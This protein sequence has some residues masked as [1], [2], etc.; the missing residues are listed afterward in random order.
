MITAVIRDVRLAGEKPK[1]DEV[2]EVDQNTPLTW[3]V[4][5][6][7]SLSDSKKG[8]VFL[9]IMAHGGGNSGAPRNV[10][11]QGGFGI[12]F[13]REWIQVDTLWMLNPLRDKL[14]GVDLLSCGAAYITPGF[15]GKHGDGNFLC[16]RM[17]QTLR[18]T[19]RASTA[20]QSYQAHGKWTDSHDPMDFGG[21]E[22][23]VFTYDKTGA[24]IKVEH[25]PEK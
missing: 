19:V 12:M 22:G 10:V 5:W 17:A 16:Y 14:K 11:S 25:K 24:V 1:G 13:C 18:T 20:T 4:Q 8:D 3:P 6:L 9:K 21:W 2:L 23:T 7:V 15:E